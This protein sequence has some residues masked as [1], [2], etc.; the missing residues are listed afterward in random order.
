MLIL[1]LR[2]KN[3]GSAVSTTLIHACA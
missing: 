1:R 3:C 2:A